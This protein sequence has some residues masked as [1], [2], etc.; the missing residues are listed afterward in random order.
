MVGRYD[1]RQHTTQSATAELAIVVPG[2]FL[3]E[4]EVAYED[5]E[6]EPVLV[7]VEGLRS[8]DGR[9]LGWEIAGTDGVRRR[10]AGWLASSDL[11]LPPVAVTRAGIGSDG[12]PGNG[13]D[14]GPAAVG[15]VGIG[16]WK[17]VLGC[18]W[19]CGLCSYLTADHQA[20]IALPAHITSA[21]RLVDI[22]CHFSP[23]SF[24][25]LMIEFNL[26]VFSSCLCLTSIFLFIEF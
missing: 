19:A 24:F 23:S 22:F 2:D 12:S 18:T 5:P 9:H 10:P 16:T 14:P 25:V 20:E 13:G 6:I 17:D 4:G 3:V 8:R 1:S 15:W 11:D 7:P 26:L 21:F